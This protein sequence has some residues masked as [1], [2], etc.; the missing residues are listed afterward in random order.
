MS[1]STRVLIPVSPGENTMAGYFFTR[2]LVI[3]TGI[4]LTL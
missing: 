1:L 4:F 2:D 3:S